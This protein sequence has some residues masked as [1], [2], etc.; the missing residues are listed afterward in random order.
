MLLNRSPES[1]RIRSEE[2]MLSQCASCGFFVCSHCES[3]V[4]QFCVPQGLLCVGVGDKQ[5]A[6]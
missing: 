1:G 3:V 5:L 4:R 2:G 6:A